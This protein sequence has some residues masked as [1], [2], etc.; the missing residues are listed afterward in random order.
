MP[1]LLWRRIKWGSGAPLRV[2]TL[3][4]V[5]SLVVGAGWAVAARAQETARPLLSPARGHA[6]VVAQGL[7]VPPGEEV[8]WRVTADRFEAGATVVA[9]RVGPGFVV[10][11]EGALL[12]A[13]DPSGRRALLAAGE[14]AFVAGGADLTREDV[15][16]GGTRSFAIELVAADQIGADPPVGAGSGG[17]REQLYASPAFSAPS[18]ERD[19]DLVRD[20]LSPGEVTSLVAGEAPT[21][22]LATLG[23]VDVRAGTGDPTTLATGEAA[24]FSGPLEVVGGDQ[25]RAVFVAAVIGGTPGG[26][27]AA[28]PLATPGASTTGRTGAITAIIAACPAGIAAAAA[29][30]TRCPRDAAAIELLLTDLDGSDPRLPV[31]TD[32]TEGVP[33]WS[34]L[35]F[36]D[37]ALRATTLGKGFDR[38]L[39]PGLPGIGGPPETGYPLAAE[40]GY[41]IRLSETAPAIRLDVYALTLTGTDDPA[42]T[43]QARTETRDR[44]GSIAIRPLL[45]PA[46]DLAA[47]DVTACQPLSVPFDAALAGGDPPVVRDLADA[48]ATTD[49][50]LLWGAL[51]LGDYA[52]TEPF[53]PVGAVSYY[54]PSSAAVGLLP[55]GS[56]YGIALTVDEP[57]IVVDVYHLAVPPLPPPVPTV[58]LPP[59]VAATETPVGVVAP[60]VA[61]TVAPVAPVA[62]PV[63]LDSDGDGLTD[64]AEAGLGT[65]PLVFDG[66]GDGIGDGAEVATGTDPFTPAEPVVPVPPPPAVPIDSDSDGDGLTDDVEAGLGTDPFNDDSDGDGWLDS[67]EI[68]LGT[69]PLDPT[70]LPQ[71]P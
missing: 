54:I 44:P 25:G 27:P 47:L 38:Y 51:P 60:T 17:S 43:P 53:L 49:G 52:F 15:R 31:V 64:E 18:G 34:G 67:N 21:L 66:D 4:V 23:E 56:G 70:S 9:E 3:L 8:V 40:T 20:L 58:A 10:A 26:E 61:A 69:D 35:P 33:I 11:D 59:A 57:T 48:E 5:L 41:R 68:N 22:V 42:A 36:G 39:V 37:Y 7:A 55:D 65:D 28:T 1:T 14:A 24:A 12:V 30:P 29:N 45:C 71:S 62:P 63:A 19:L 16:G 46:S 32:G 50:T 6:Q 2:V 13:G